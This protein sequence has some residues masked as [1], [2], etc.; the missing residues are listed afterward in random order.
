MNEKA[1]KNPAT[2]GRTGRAGNK[3]MKNVTYDNSFKS[4]GQEDY[5]EVMV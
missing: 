1:K 4:V 3:E 5:S 2:L